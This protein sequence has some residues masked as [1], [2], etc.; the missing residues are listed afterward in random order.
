MQI[1]V[2][3]QEM[4]GV[5]EMK[6]KNVALCGFQCAGPSLATV[7]W[8]ACTTPQAWLANVYP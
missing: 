6:H 8:K 2:R 7:F 4:L 5:P 3:L 1:C